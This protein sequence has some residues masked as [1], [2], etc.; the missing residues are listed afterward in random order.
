MSNAIHN[1]LLR[2]AKNPFVLFLLSLAAF[3]V[4]FLS[5]EL[6]TDLPH[7][8]GLVIRWLA[9]GLFLVTIIYAMLINL[10]R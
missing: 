1:K 10:K 4:F 3:G 5:V 7:Y 6:T 9:G 8:V 2:H